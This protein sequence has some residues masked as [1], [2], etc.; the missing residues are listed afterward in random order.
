MPGGRRIDDDE[1]VGAARGE[2]RDLEERRKLVESR[3]SRATSS[4]SSHVPRRAIRSR[5]LRRVSSHR[6]SAAAASISTASSRPR[7]SGTRCG[8]DPSG[9]DNASPS[10]GAGSVETTSVRLPSRAA[11]RAMAAAQ[12]VL[13]TP[14]LPPT[15]R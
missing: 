9:R 1:V 6:P 5:C 4:S 13:P 11:V 12:V 7:R 15:N 8:A 14:P 2:A 10:D 3:S